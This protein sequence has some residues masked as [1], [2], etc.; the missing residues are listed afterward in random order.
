VVWRVKELM[1]LRTAN[2]RMRSSQL[3]YPMILDYGM[4]E[5]PQR[6][7]DLQILG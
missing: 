7:N 2:S 6:S 1:N 5:H 4:M 3:F